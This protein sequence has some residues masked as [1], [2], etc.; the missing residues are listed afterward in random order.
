MFP[1]M[2]PCFAWGLFQVSL[3]LC[4]ALRPQSPKGESVLNKLLIKHLR[5]SWGSSEQSERRQQIESHRFSKTGNKLRMRFQNLMCWIKLPRMILL[6]NSMIYQMPMEYYSLS[7][8]NWTL[9]VGMHH[10]NDNTKKSLA[11]L[12]QV[13]ASI[14]S[15]NHDCKPI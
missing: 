4:C 12:R 7:H 9:W 10:N 3:L 5:F 13:T 15:G 1:C 14:L 6:S 2:C 11:Q 8:C